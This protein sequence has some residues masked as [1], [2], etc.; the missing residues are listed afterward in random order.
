MNGSPIWAYHSTGKW[1]LYSHSG[2]FAIS[3]SIKTGASLA[4]GV[5]INSAPDM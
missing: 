3:S 1:D 2:E 5:R 4:G